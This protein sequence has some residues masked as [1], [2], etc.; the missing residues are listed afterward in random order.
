MPK[1]LIRRVN[2]DFKP[3]QQNFFLIPKQLGG[4]SSRTSLDWQKVKFDA[5]NRA[6]VP[7][8]RGIYAFVVE[9]NDSELPPHGYV[10]Y[11]GISGDR[12]EH[13]L[14]KR[15]GDY[16]REKKI[17][18]RVRVHYMLNNWSGCL[19]FHYAVVSDKRVNLHKLEKGVSD[20]LMPPFST[21]DFSAKV[22][23]SRRAF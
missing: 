2:E 3:Y 16:L 21:N 23:Q 7:E 6:A 4:F 10:M 15:Y 8:G 22:R 20:A 14:R 5:S 1:D 9:H 18:K 13:N 17:Q 12:S 19:F 11:V